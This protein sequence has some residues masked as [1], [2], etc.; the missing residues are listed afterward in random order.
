MNVVQVG[1]RKMWQNSWMREGSSGL[2]C[3]FFSGRGERGLGE[4]GSVGREEGFFKSNGNSRKIP[5]GNEK[6]KK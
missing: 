1:R 4:G 2:G 3:F 5:V 6:L